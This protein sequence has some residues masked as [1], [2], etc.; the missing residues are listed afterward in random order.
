M[1]LLCQFPHGG[2]ID[3]RIRSTHDKGDPFGQGSIGIAHR[4]GDML[5]VIGLHGCF[6]ISQA[7]VYALL[8]RY[9]DLCGSSPEHNN[10]AAPLL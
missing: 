1:H 7:I 4:G 9:I 5:A 3:R 6:E 10:S 2:D 8:D